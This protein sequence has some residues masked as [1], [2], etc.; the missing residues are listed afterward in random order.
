MHAL[1]VARLGSDTT[2]ALYA[3]GGFFF[4]GGGAAASIA[5]WNGAFWSPLGAGIG[6]Y[7]SAMALAAYDDG[8]NRGASLF[9]GGGF[10]SAGGIASPAIA[11][12]VGCPVDDPPRFRP[13]RY[14]ATLIDSPSDPSWDFRSTPSE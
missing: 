4:A 9:V 6:G 11:K 14:D 12:W 2:P 10:E 8:S 1:R 3:A 7:G 13:C 5:R